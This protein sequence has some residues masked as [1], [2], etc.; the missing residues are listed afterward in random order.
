MFTNEDFADYVVCVWNMYMAK[1]INISKSELE[2]C[3][4]Y[5]YVKFCQH[6]HLQVQPLVPIRSIMKMVM[7][8]D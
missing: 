3:I 4:N 1:Q 7:L 2:D 6:R 5:Y 8:P